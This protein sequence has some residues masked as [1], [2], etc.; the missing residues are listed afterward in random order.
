MTKFSE[1]LELNRGMAAQLSRE[2]KVSTAAIS[3][4]KRG[5]RMPPYWMPVVNKMSKGK[6]SLATLLD[7]NGSRRR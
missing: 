4:V 7:E 5:K 3:G 1:W 2:L 6:L